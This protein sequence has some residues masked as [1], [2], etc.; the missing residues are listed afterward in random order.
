[1]SPVEH[2]RRH[3]QIAALAGFL[4]MLNLPIVVSLCKLPTTRYPSWN[5]QG[6]LIAALQHLQQL[7]VKAIFVPPFRTVA[8]RAGTPA[9]KA[10]HWHGR[11]LTQVTA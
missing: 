8:P 6:Y 2:D 5:T 4:H 11:R 10:S 3:S 9:K 1:M 7:H